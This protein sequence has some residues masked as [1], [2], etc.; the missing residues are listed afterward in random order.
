MLMPER[1]AG[2]S[3]GADRWNL[4]LPTMQGMRTPRRDLLR[5]GV[6]VVVEQAIQWC[7]ENRADVWATDTVARVVGKFPPGLSVWGPPESAPAFHAK[8]I[9]FVPLK[10]NAVIG[11]GQVPRPA[12]AFFKALAFACENL[13]A[14]KVRV[15][16][17]SGLQ[18]PEIRW[19]RWAFARLQREAGA[20]GIELERVR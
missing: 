11:P 12:D 9:P 19:R 18:K 17:L 13:K 4:I 6:T 1:F 2:L 16:G 20:M 5:G 3:L 7:R 15:F 10:P 8:H 14:K